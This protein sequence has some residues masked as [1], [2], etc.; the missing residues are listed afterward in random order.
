MTMLSLSLMLLGISLAFAG[1]YV[2]ARCLYREPGDSAGRP[3]PYPQPRTCRK[4]GCTDDDCSECVRR[5]G[6]PCHWV[7]WDLCSAC[8]EVMTPEEIARYMPGPWRD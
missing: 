3:G 5:T 6:E 1:G 4:C 8:V 2:V 7:A